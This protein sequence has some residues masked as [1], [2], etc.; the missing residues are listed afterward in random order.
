MLLVG[1][2]NGWSSPYLAK[3]T[4]L[5]NVDGISRATDEQLT[6][7]ASLMNIGRIFGAVGG[8]VAQ[9]IAS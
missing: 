1:L 2:A 8:A 7:V 4:L 9:G 3:L 5:D 6:W